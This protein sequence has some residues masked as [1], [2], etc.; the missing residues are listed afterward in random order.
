MNGLEEMSLLENETL[1]SLKGLSN[2]P[3]LK[4]LILNGSKV[5]NLKEFPDLPRLE[6]LSLEGNGIS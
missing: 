4:K 6:V 1:I 3:V 2:L 5:S